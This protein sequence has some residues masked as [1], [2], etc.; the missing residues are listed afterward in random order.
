[1]LYKQGEKT[2]KLFDDYS[3]IASESNIKQNMERD[4]KY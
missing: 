4:G 2:I 3:R 1:M